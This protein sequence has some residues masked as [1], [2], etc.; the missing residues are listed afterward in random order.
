[1]FVF[2]DGNRGK[3]TC[4]ASSGG[5]STWK[6]MHEWP[7]TAVHSKQEVKPTRLDDELGADVFG[8]RAKMI[9]FFMHKAAAAT[10]CLTPQAG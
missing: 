1:M 4:S 3:E 9:C 8:R 2:E 6:K 7:S 10:H 5:E